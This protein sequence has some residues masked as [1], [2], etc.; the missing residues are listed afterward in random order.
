MLLATDVPNVIFGMN[1]CSV[2]NKSGD[3]KYVN[4]YTDMIIIP[5]TICAMHALMSA[6]CIFDFITDYY[7]VSEYA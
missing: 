2:A 1:G 4:A 3:M 6:L 5:V 7:L